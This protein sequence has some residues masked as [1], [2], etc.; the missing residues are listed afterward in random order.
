MTVYFNME[1]LELPK[2]GIG[3]SYVAKE[4]YPVEE[5][6]KTE[7]GKTHKRLKVFIEKGLKCS[8]PNCDKVGKYIIKAADAYGGVHTDMYS[9]DFTLMTVD[10]IYPKCLGGNNAMVNKQ[11]MCSPCNSKKASK[12]PDQGFHYSMVK[13]GIGIF[14]YQFD[15][16][17]H[18]L[19]FSKRLAAENLWTHEYA[20]RV[21]EEY[22]RF[23]FLAMY[24][25]HPVTPSDAVDQAWHLHLLHSKDY[26]NFCSNVMRYRLH[27]GPT[28]GGQFESDKFEDLYLK[29]KRSYK[30]AFNSEPP[31][32]IWPENKE[33]FSGNFVRLDLT[34]HLVIHKPS[35]PRLTRL[36]EWVMKRL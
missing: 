8:S 3:H 9:E 12:V 7:E 26:D 1:T 13:K 27:H 28:K 24:A 30:K 35:F 33:R 29:T 10:H 19:T 22:K 6:L 31:L 15:K 17:G 21:I 2:Q 36:L 23:C 32:D 18:E 20:L 25:G 16:S 14:E 34:Q 4:I 11:T 5:Y